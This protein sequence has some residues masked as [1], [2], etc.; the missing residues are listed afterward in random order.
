MLS[1]T[2]N[3]ILKKIPT[4]PLTARQKAE[5]VEAAMTLSSQLDDDASDSDDDFFDIKKNSK[6]QQQQQED[7]QSSTG[8]STI[9]SVVL[10][11]DVVLPNVQLYALSIELPVSLLYHAT[12]H[13]SDIVS[14]F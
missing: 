11:D 14:S 6:Q 1:T 13:N 3:G 10:I 2:S 7:Q 12:S 4:P 9:A 5:Q 8:N